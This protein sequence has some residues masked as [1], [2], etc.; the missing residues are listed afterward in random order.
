MHVDREARQ[1]FAELAEQ[2]RTLAYTLSI[3]NDITKG[4]SGPGG[5]AS[6]EALVAK[7]ARVI[8]SRGFGALATSSMDEHSTLRRNR[9]V[10]SPMPSAFPREKTAW[11]RSCAGGSKEKRRL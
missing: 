1:F 4:S 6:A 8:A 3:W 9:S 5:C 2:W 7:A 10:H 11:I